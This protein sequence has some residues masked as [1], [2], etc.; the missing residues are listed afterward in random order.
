M[1]TG[2]IHGGINVDT[3]CIGAPPSAPHVHGFLI[4]PS[5]RTH[6]PTFKSFQ[7]LSGIIS[8]KQNFPIDYLDELE[9]FYYVLAWMC[10]AYDGGVDGKPYF[11]PAYRRSSPLTPW[12]ANPTSREAILEKEAMLFGTGLRYSQAPVSNFW[13]GETFQ[14][15]LDNLHYVIRSRYIAKTELG[16]PRTMEELRLD[17]GEDY[18]AC[19]G[20]INTTLFKLERRVRS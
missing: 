16:R 7:S 9:S 5:A 1:S 15:L 2:A 6:D 17:A 18:E 19:L 11:T 3:I 12:A 13:G 20:I 10:Y 14:E 8:R 4:E